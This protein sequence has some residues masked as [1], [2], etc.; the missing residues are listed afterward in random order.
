MTYA[1]G[2][3][4]VVVVVEATVRLSCTLNTNNS[5]CNV[6]I[7]T[8]IPQNQYVTDF[9]RFVLDPGLPLILK[10]NISSSKIFNGSIVTLYNQSSNSNMKYTATAA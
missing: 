3:S 4:V 9:N 2:G 8:K 10:L 5:N 6:I 7:A 1:T